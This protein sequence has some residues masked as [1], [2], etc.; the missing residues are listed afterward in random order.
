[1]ASEEQTMWDWL[2]LRRNVEADRQ[3]DVSTISCWLSRQL[4][5]KLS[6]RQDFTF[7]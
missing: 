1:M 4:R 5:R 6:R 2:L 7:S 3:A